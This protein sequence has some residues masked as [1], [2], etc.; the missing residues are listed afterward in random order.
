MQRAGKMAGYAMRTANKPKEEE[1]EENV[2]GNLK[3]PARNLVRGSHGWAKE[4]VA[5]AR[6]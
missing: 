1:D 4:S 6:L 2:T 5:R 3:Q